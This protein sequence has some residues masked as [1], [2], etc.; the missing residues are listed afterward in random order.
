MKKRAMLVIILIAAITGCSAL[1]KKESN[2]FSGEEIEILKATTQ[3][4]GYDYGYD[5]E[6]DLD[7]VFSHSYS[8][9]DVKGRLLKI[10]KALDRFDN[11][12]LIKFYEKVYI[13][14]F[15]TIKVQGKY[16]ELK[17]W[18]YYTHVNK[19]L[20]PSLE[21]YLQLL[22]E[23]LLVKVPEYRTRIATRKKEIEDVFHK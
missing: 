8:D 9:K 6:P 5:S 23:Q 22:E 20:L 11:S 13:L 17:E 7:Y 3:A 21:K 1:V 19:Y 12:S 14:R 18:K 16:R 2:F 4:I 15:K 10:K